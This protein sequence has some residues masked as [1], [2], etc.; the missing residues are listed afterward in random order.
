[1]L[2]TVTAAADN[3]GIGGI[4]NLTPIGALIGLI[5]LIFWLTSTG[6][7]IPRSSHEREMAAAN[8]RGD[9][10]KETA[11]ETRV[12]NVALVKQNSILVESTKTSA[13]FFGTV[14]RDGGGKHVGKEEPSST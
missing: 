10:W 8:K 12:L 1:M 9:E 3:I 5:V 14:T 7:Y 2:E 4:W 6:R 11:I 13:E